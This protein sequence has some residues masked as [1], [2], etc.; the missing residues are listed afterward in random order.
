[1]KRILLVMGVLIVSAILFARGS[2]RG[3]S[4]GGGYYNRGYMMEEYAEKK[5]SDR[6]TSYNVCYTKLLR[7][8]YTISSL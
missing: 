6:I 1:M 8:L 3:Y 7:F 5:L 2:G 4:S